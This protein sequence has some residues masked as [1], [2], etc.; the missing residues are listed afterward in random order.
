MKGFRFSNGEIYILVKINFRNVVFI[1]F[2]TLCLKL[3]KYVD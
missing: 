1:Y 3:I 2:S